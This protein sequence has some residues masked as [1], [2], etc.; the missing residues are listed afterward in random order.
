MLY[1]SMIPQSHVAVRVKTL[2]VLC[3]KYEFEII[4]T[5]SLC[6]CCRCRPP[7]HL[8]NHRLL[9]NSVSLSKNKVDM[10]INH[11]LWISHCHFC[12][13]YMNTKKT[14]D[15]YYILLLPFTQATFSVMVLLPMLL[16]ENQNRFNWKQN[17]HE[18]QICVINFLFIFKIVFQEIANSRIHLGLTTKHCHWLVI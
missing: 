15:W 7:F 3:E 14:C 1:S 2:L 10:I 11:P 5:I 9:V 13:Y 18:Y 6:L 4:L 16:K 12:T 17:L 8:L